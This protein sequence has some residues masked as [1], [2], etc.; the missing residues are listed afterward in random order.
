MPLAY[1]LPFSLIYRKNIAIKALME[2][3]EKLIGYFLTIQCRHIIMFCTQPYSSWNEAYTIKTLMSIAFWG[4]WKDLHIRHS[5]EPWAIM[6]SKKGIRKSAWNCVKYS[7]DCSLIRSRPQYTHSKVLWQVVDSKESRQK[8]VE[9]IPKN[10]NSWPQRPI[11]A[12]S[13]TTRKE[14]EEPSGG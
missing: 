13:H 14:G 12:V 7:Q 9:E 1:H 3:V 4:L 6:H 11:Y 8:H 10:S 5:R 2:I